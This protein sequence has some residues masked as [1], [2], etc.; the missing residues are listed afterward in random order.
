L[1][2]SGVVDVVS[3]GVG[4][5]VTLGVTGAGVT[6]GE[7]VVVVVSWPNAPTL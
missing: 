6:E 5:S 7:V 3:V 1:V 4:D 2:G